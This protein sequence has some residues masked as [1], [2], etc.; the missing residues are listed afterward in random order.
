[1]KPPD[2]PTTV[3]LPH[4]APDALP[5]SRTIARVV[6]IVLVVIGTIA[7]VRLLWQPIAWIVVATFLAVA[8]SGPVNVLARRMRRG[9]AITIV[10]IGL[11]LVPVTVASL[12]MPPLVRQG[13]DFVNDLPRYSRDLDETIQKSDRLRSLNED[14][15]VTQELKKLANDAPQRIGE[16]AGVL[17]DVGTGLVNSIFAGFTIFV[18]SIFMVARGRD[19]INGFLRLRGG[20]SSE[21]ISG[22]LDRIGHAVGS[23]VGGA[24][25]QATVA[26][27]SAFVML[28]I[29]GVPF[30]GALAIVM[31]L[32]DLIPLVG[33]TLA[34]ILIGVVTL[35]NDFPSDMVVWAIFAVA[36]QQFENYVIQPQIQKRA[37][38]LEP[39]VILVSVL[40]GGTLFGIAGALLAIPTAATVQISLQEWWH[41]RTGQQLV[42]VGVL[43]EPPEAPHSP[44][45]AAPPHAP[46]AP[47]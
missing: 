28:T 11:A 8:L 17:R 1:M 19:W 24:I 29:L 37:V 13:V 35:F 18:L 2:A 40:F 34:A 7:L 46:P 9:L 43:P 31:A 15:G 47:A 44:P 39:F 10:Y 14:L 25:V 16:A 20:A 21:A 27:V 23:Y 26:G 32:G 3:L 42:V 30:A 6:L 4:D 38:E 5:T 12:L 41:Y 33:A 36:Y 22:A 45:D